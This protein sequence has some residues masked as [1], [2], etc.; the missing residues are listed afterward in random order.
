MSWA[1]DEWKD[2]LNH[3]AL[4]KIAEIE[5]QNEILKKETKQKQFLMESLEASSNKQKRKVEEDKIEISALKRE[6][7]SL[8]EDCTKLQQ[9]VDKLSNELKHKE[10]HISGLEGQYQRCKYQL[11]QYSCKTPKQGKSVEEQARDFS[12]KI[13]ELQSLLDQEKARTRTL[14]K[15]INDAKNSQSARR[16]SF[17]TPLPWATDEPL[18]TPVKPQRPLFDLLTGSPVSVSGSGDSNPPLLLPS[19]NNQPTPTILPLPLITPPSD[20]SDLLQKVSSLEKEITI[21]SEEIST[22]RQKL[23]ESVDKVSAAEDKLQQLSNE[24]ASDREKHQVLVE[25]LKSKQEDGRKRKEKEWEEERRKWEEQLVEQKNKFNETL[26]EAKRDLKEIQTE[27][28]QTSLNRNKLDSELK[29]SSHKLL[30]MEQLHQSGQTKLKQLQTSEQVLMK[31]NDSLSSQLEKMSLKLESIETQRDSLKSEN[32]RLH[33]S[34]SDK[35]LELEKC[36]VEIKAERVKFEKETNK[37][38]T[39]LDKLRMEFDE[40]EKQK[41]QQKDRLTQKEEEVTKLRSQVSHIENNSSGAINKLEERSNEVEALTKEN[42]MLLEQSEAVVGELKK[43]KCDLEKLREGYEVEV[44]G[45]V[46]QHQDEVEGLKT[47]IKNL[48]ENSQEEVR[49]LMLGAEEEMRTLSGRLKEQEGHLHQLNVMCDEKQRILDGYKK[50]LDEQVASA[51]AAKE[52]HLVL[53]EEYRKLCEQ[54]EVVKVQVCRLESEGLRLVSVNQELQNQLA[55]HGTVVESLQQDICSLKKDKLALVE[56]MVNLKRTSEGLV[57]SLQKEVENTQSESREQEVLLKTRMDQVE[58]LMEKNQNLG[59]ELEDV[60]KLFEESK[61]Q[62]ESHE[63]HVKELEQLVENMKQVI[64]EKQDEYEEGLVGMRLRCEDAES[65]LGVSQSEVESLK[66][67]LEDVMSEKCKAAD[68][69][70]HREE[71]LKVVE[72]K[73]GQLTEEVGKLQKMYDNKIKD[74]NEKEQQLKQVK[75]STEILEQSVLLR[76]SEIGRISLEFDEYRE[77]NELLVGSLNKEKDNL[78][79]K[80]TALQSDLDKSENVVSG[81]NSTCQSFEVRVETLEHDLAKSVGN[82]ELLEMDMESKDEILLKVEEKLSHAED[83]LHQKETSLKDK[84]TELMK[85]EEEFEGKMGLVEELR[86]KNEDM[87]MKLKQCY[88][89]LEVR[90]KQLSEASSKLDETGKSNC[91]LLEELQKVQALYQ[92]VVLV[93]EQTETDLRD[94]KSKMEQQNQVVDGLQESLEESRAENKKLVLE[95]DSSVI[96][97]SRHEKELDG[98]KSVLKETQI[99]SQQIGEAL[100]QEKISLEKECEKYKDDLEA[101]KVEFGALVQRNEEIGVILEDSHAQNENL[102]I[103]CNRYMEDNASLREEVERMNADLEK[104]SQSLVDLEMQFNDV[105]WKL[106]DVEVKNRDVVGKMTRE[107]EMYKEERNNMEGELIALQCVLETKQKEENGNNTRIDELKD[108]IENLEI[109]SEKVSKDLSQ[110][111][112]E[113]EE[114]L[115]E[116]KGLKILNENLEEKLQKSAEDLSMVDQQYKEQVKVLG[117]RLED[118]EDEVKML[119]EEA[120]NGNH[121]LDCQV[122][123]GLDLEAEISVL[124]TKQD[125]L[126][127][128]IAQ[129]DEVVLSLSDENKD[130]NAGRISLQKDYEE[131]VQKLEVSSQECTDLCEKVDTEVEKHEAHVGK[132]EQRVVGL[133]DV[134]SSL[135]DKVEELVVQ[136]EGLG[137]QVQRSEVDNEGLMEEVKCSQDVVAMKDNELHDMECKYQQLEVDLKDKEIQFAE[138]MAALEANMMQDNVDHQHQVEELS[139]KVGS[140]E[141]VNTRLDESIEGYVRRLDEFKSTVAELVLVNQR[142]QDD[143][144]SKS[145]NIS[146]LKDDICSLKDK[147]EK[148][149]KEMEEKGNLESL[150]EEKVM[151]GQC[152][153]EGLKEELHQSL[154]HSMEMEQFCSELRKS[155]EETGKENDLKLESFEQEIE[156]LKK[157]VKTSENDYQEKLSLNLQEL[158]SVKEKCKE[159]TL[160]LEAV[161]RQNVELLEQCAAGKER[162]CH[163]EEKIDLKGNE[164]SVKSEDLE[165]IK[166]ELCFE[167]EK[168]TNYSEEIRKLENEV[169]SLQSHAVELQ[170]HHESALNGYYEKLRVTEETNKMLEDDLSVA[171]REIKTDCAALKDKSMKISELEQNIENLEAKLRQTVEVLDETKLKLGSVESENSSLKHGLENSESGFKTRVSELEATLV[172]REVYEEHRKEEMVKLK[173]VLSLNEQKLQDLLAEERRLKCE[174]KTLEKDK[175]SSKQRSVSMEIKITELEQQLSVAMTT[176][177]KLQAEQRLHVDAVTLAEKENKEV[178]SELEITIHELKNDL[179]KSSLKISNR[180]IEVEEKLHEM[181]E[182]FDLKV[183]ENDEISAENIKLENEVSMLRE[184][185]MEAQSHQ[186]LMVCGLKEDNVGLV[187]KVEVLEGEVH[188]LKREG[189]IVVEQLDGL[190][191]EGATVVEQLEGEVD[192][193]KR[194]G[195]T[196]K[197]VLEGKVDRLKREGATVVEELEDEVD[198]LKREGT[199]V[200]EELEGKHNEVNNL[201][202]Q[203]ESTELQSSALTVMIAEME[204]ARDVHVK[205]YKQLDDQLIKVRSDFKTEVATLEERNQSLQQKLEVSLD[206]IRV[207][208]E[209]LACD[210]R[211]VEELRASLSVAVANIEEL[212]EVKGQFSE[213]ENRHKNLVSEY[214]VMEIELLRV[215]GENDDL[216]VDVGRLREVVEERDGE[217]KGMR[218]KLHL[219]ENVIS[220]AETSNSQMSTEL[221]KLNEAIQQE[222]SISKR[223]IS[224][225]EDENE[226]L[227]REVSVLQLEVDGMKKEEQGARDA[228]MMSKDRIRSL[229]DEVAILEREKQKLE[230]TNDKLKDDHSRLQLDA[231]QL[232]VDLEDAGSSLQRM[233]EDKDGLIHQ[234]ERLKNNLVESSHNLHE[235]ESVLDD[236]KLKIEDNEQTNI[237]AMLNL[238]T[239]NGDLTRKV[240]DVTEKLIEAEQREQSFESRFSELEARSLKRDM[241]LDEAS[242]KAVVD[243][244]IMRKEVEVL[245]ANNVKLSEEIENLKITEVLSDS[246]LESA[247]ESLMHAREELNREV[248]RNEELKNQVEGLKSSRCNDDIFTRVKQL[249]EEKLKLEKEVEKISGKLK[250]MTLTARR[251]EK[252]LIRYQQS[253]KPPVHSTDKSH[254][255]ESSQSGQSKHVVR[256]KSPRKS[257]GKSLRMLVGN[258][259]EPTLAPRVSEGTS[260]SASPVYQLEGLPHLVKKGFADIPQGFSSP[261]VMRR[262]NLTKTKVLVAEALASKKQPYHTQETRIKKERSPSK[263]QKLHPESKLIKKDKKLGKSPSSSLLEAPT[264]LQNITNSPKQSPSSLLPPSGRQTARALSLT[265]TDEIHSSQHSVDNCKTQ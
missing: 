90:E 81:L 30:Q 239:T 18:V 23:K 74:L 153:V 32:Q 34:L 63:R 236:Q 77:R 58:A 11:E 99:M 152:E 13:R 137:D 219:L 256:R 15:E 31:E 1:G 180:E 115:S 65:R 188:Q 217:V 203:V 169:K 105:E 240:C 56:E 251:K 193:L 86:S 135:E 255:S 166:L 230:D 97:I 141:D 33:Q 38:E 114:V 177:D 78:N 91:G 44:A 173:D 111:M 4:G 253:S 60:R 264:L 192:R 22:L 222:S 72:Q 146:Q 116:V 92:D 50:K 260:G 70:Q 127:L 66:L 234:V 161:K 187:D 185:L 37:L 151:K 53:K 246:K 10:V 46:K 140:L 221:R 165:K 47:K 197:E 248:T 227:R 182:E 64:E 168:N 5:K 263:P 125:D 102:E 158:D 189:A 134:K 117:G 119:K 226:D 57:S 40:V 106:E 79:T 120:E 59:S 145:L 16:Q 199:T 178:R 172:E 129:K 202:K 245:E 54:E 88:T 167:L 156:C 73:V 218:E 262:Q 154:Q 244:N 108:Q 233:G 220:E 242:R 7:H 259:S 228:M 265:S 123:R 62:V 36:N 232:R 109:S 211:E 212:K 84:E 170:S 133:E 95:L 150:L 39:E 147:E 175:E 247:L 110:K 100:K 94:V 174:I 181:R 2:G 136:L 103:L 6:N 101:L 231:A 113:T 261:H 71:S 216:M 195:T 205:E 191:M 43:T 257:G 210:K 124:K 14:E 29:K 75:N 225:M 196:V 250:L 126:L 80:I 215:G 12:S 241:E 139:L 254:D 160:E 186:D 35:K 213:I 96:K 206:D 82:A 194:E 107:V 26:S 85:L 190:K 19:S 118:A 68:L 93:K 52:E 42:N 142:L 224:S 149:L 209:Y 223:R 249:T 157:S 148:L 183:K 201:M 144:E 229:E 17:M 48:E 55:N 171:R 27:L 98:L 164:V 155:A 243:F 61:L 184:S 130:L 20:D 131:L 162:V 163:L 28:D 204:A 128:K 132:L 179:E 45:V 89:D 159:V 87:G 252:E 21:K 208:D 104:S 24:V 112:L 3:K 207:K 143:L 51:E 198:R 238:Q 121:Q 41:N 214:E 25:D 176:I 69:A 49:R 76:E 237:V 83:C 9:K 258:D 8:A 67:S 200:K 235:L 122:Q 138:S